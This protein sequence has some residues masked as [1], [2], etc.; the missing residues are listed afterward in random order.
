MLCISTGSIFHLAAVLSGQAEKE[1]D[2][3][4]KVRSVEINDWI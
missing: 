2:L 1:E 4:F 3:G